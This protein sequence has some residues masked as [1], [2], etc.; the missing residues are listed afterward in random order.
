MLFAEIYNALCSDKQ[1]HSRKSQSFSRGSEPVESTT[2]CTTQLGLQISEESST[3]IHSWSLGLQADSTWIRWR[4]CDKESVTIT[5]IIST[6]LDRIASTSTRSAYFETCIVTS[7]HQTRTNPFLFRSSSLSSSCLF[8]TVRLRILAA[9]HASPE[10]F[11][12]PRPTT[13]RRNAS[14]HLELSSDGP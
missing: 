4:P 11:A 13:Q 8:V 10:E 5:T 14:S 3:F 12:K 7:L 9:F 6:Y 2:S 1:A